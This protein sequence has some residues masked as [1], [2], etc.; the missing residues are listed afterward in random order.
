MRPGLSQ[1]KFDA[2]GQP[3]GRQLGGVRAGRGHVELHRWRAVR[4]LPRTVEKL[5]SPIDWSSLNVSAWSAF[6]PIGMMVA[7]LS[8]KKISPVRSSPLKRAF[9][10]SQYPFSQGKPESI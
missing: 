4:S 3:S 9:E 8:V 1:T 5:T 2:A 7:C 6:W 10:F